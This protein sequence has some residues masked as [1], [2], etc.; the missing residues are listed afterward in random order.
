MIARL[1]KTSIAGR[2]EGDGLR[3]SL[4]M[5]GVCFSLGMLFGLLFATLGESSPE[6][7]DYL[8]QYFQ[9][10]VS[11]NGWQPAVWSVVW[12]LIRWPAA[13][14]VFGFTALGAFCIPALFLTR[15]FLLSYAISLFVR[16]FGGRGM[17]AALA[18][19]G[20]A[21]FLATPVL[22]AMGC[23]A[24]RSSLCRIGDQKELAVCSVQQKLTT[25]IPSAGLMVA[26]S[27]LQCTV[28]PVLLRSVCTRFFAP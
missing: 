7:S 18:S 2:T 14:F 28:M 12:D 26:A 3:F 6:L 15:G 10:V 16:L 1:S 19:F 22:F 13:V 8:E 5:L 25:L 17:L 23:D 9:A 24:F 27:V 4:L 11:D 21:A 20:V